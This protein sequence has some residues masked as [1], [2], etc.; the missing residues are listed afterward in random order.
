MNRKI[1]IVVA[2]AALVALSLFAITSQAAE[3]PA[4]EA[5]GG[6]DRMM[7]QAVEQGIINSEQAGRMNAL[8]QQMGPQMHEQMQEA[9]QG[10]MPEHCNDVTVK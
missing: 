1:V 7:Q 8:M 10:A 3:A 2:L 4:A 9:H 6:H 5:C